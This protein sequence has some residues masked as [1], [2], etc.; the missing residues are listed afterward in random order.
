MMG[1][2]LN[3]F[4]YLLY[5]YVYHCWSLV[6]QARPFICCSP[7]HN[8]NHDMVKNPQNQCMLSKASGKHGHPYIMIRVF[9]VLSKGNLGLKL[10]S[11]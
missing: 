4:D 7:R 8:M 11:C 2:Y 10:S 9:G 1:L 6:D 5:I 3:V